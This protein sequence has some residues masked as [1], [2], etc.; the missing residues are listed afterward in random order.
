MGRFATFGL[1]AVLICGPAFLARGADAS[2]QPGFKTMKRP[3]LVPTTDGA[4]MGVQTDPILSTGDIVH[5]YQMSGIPD[6]LGAFSDRHRR[7]STFTTM[8]NHELDRTFPNPPFNPGVDARISKLEVDSDTR[9]VLSASYPFTGNENFTRFCSA[10][11]RVFGNTPYYFTG[12]ETSTSGQRGSSIVMNARTGAWRETRHFGLLQHENVVPVHLS[13]WVFVT[14]DDDFRVGQPAY[15]YAYISPSFHG[16]L[17]GTRG[18]LHVFVS[19]TH[20]ANAD[21]QKGEVVQGNFVPISQAEN[22]TPESLKNAATARGAFKFDRLE[23]AAAVRGN[24]SRLYIADTGKPPP[25]SP[26][27]RG[28]IYQFD[29]SHSHPTR[30]TMRL[31][32][33]GDPPDND[34]IFNPDNLDASERALIIQEDRES[35]YRTDWNYVLMYPF[36]NGPLTR[37]ARVDTDPNLPKGQW[38]S[39]GVIDARQ[40]LGRDWWLVDVQ[41]HSRLEFQPGPTLVPNSAQGED[42]Q[43]LALKIPGSQGGRGH[44]DDDDDDDG[45]D[46]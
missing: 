7:A 44:D 11:L 21:V 19:S 5:G 32:L 8:M 22:A 10:T 24:E 29:I 40:F 23:D 15:L 3:Y 14:T 25:T 34:N 38:E 17:N 35:A 45:D 30:A 1:A 28:R 6:G 16:A 36:P 41:A 42:G 46:E 18:S 12:E 13:K 33:N 27:P 39:S 2:H 26:T 31:V 9:H 20:A 37:V 4:A 43:F